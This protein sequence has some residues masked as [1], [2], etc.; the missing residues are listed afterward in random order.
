V[1][2]L[3]AIAL[4]VGIDLSEFQPVAYFHKDMDCIRVLTHD[5]S[6]TEHRINEFYTVCEAN[7]RGPF[8]PKYVG[9][10]INGA[11]QLF[12]DIGLSLDQTHKLAYV[13]ER[14]VNH[15]PGSVMS[16]TLSLIFAQ[17]SPGDLS[18]LEAA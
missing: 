10:V 15:L 3:K 7:Y 11:R 12:N 18:L 2:E 17:V 16:E 13:I 14:L 1:S 4:P 8:D 9:F 5:R 6:T